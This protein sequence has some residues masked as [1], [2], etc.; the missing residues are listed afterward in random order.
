MVESLGWQVVGVL[1]GLSRGSTIL[2]IMAD[3]STF[4]AVSLSHAF[5]MLLQG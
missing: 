5:S 4:E 3:L 1:L 2:G